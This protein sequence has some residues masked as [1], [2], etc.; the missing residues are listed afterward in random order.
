MNV[1][2]GQILSMGS[3]PTYDPTVFTRPM[4]QRQVDAL[5]RDPIA[6]PL[7]NRAIQGLYPTG[8]TFKLVTAMAALNSQVNTFSPSFPITDGGVLVVGDIPFQN[9]G[10][11]AYGTITLP[12]ALQVSSDVFFY[13]LG[14]WMNGTPSLQRWA[15]RLGIGRRTGIDL[16]GESSGL[17]PTPKW[18]NELY[19]DGE[20][21][22]PWSAGDNVNLA[23]GQGDVQ[24]DPLQLAVAYA[25]V[26]NGGRVVTP[27]LG[28]RIEDSAGRAV[29]EINPG[30]RR[31][32]RVDP[33]YREAILD[34]LHLAAQAPGGTSY[35]VFGG[36]PIPVAGK[37]GTAER[38]PYGDQSWYS[39]LAPYPD[40]RIVVTVTV[41]RGGFGA[42]T[43]APIAAQILSQYFH[44]SSRPVESSGAPLE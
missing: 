15:H 9:A 43:A 26:G 39:V 30:A 11:A 1:N 23:V 6:A 31:H 16:P 38:P 27:H 10:G 21:D 42:D 4:T 3:Y 22:R 20:T 2:N 28:M 40:P 7:T 32:V 5:Y 33:V 35:A 29:E 25:T 18:R 8:S 14:Y 37:T 13:T 41:E 34:G 44:V 24:V 36:F 12:T 17:L 19:A